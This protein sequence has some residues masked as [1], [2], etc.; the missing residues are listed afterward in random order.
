MHWHEIKEAALKQCEGKDPIYVERLE[1]EFK[2][3]EKQASEEYWEEVITK[4]ESFGRNPN[5][6]VLP[7]LLGITP[8]DPLVGEGAAY[9][10]EGYDRELE[11][12][13][14][15]LDNGRRVLVAKDTLVRTARGMIPAGAL[16]VDDELI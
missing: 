9:I 16:R 15:E 3:I 8:I 4:G 10:G 13:E 14:I 5:G 1:F 11:A 12:V 2:E 6:L 7:F